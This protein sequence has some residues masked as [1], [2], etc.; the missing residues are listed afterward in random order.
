[1]LDTLPLD[2]LAGSAAEAT[3]R[4]AESSINELLRAGE[5]PLNGATIAI[6][7]GNQVTVHY[8]M[9]H[10]RATLEPELEIG[11]APRLTVTLASFMVAVA[12][13]AALR[14]PYVTLSGRRL[15]IDLA[16]VPA[17]APMARYWPHLRR[18]A[19]TTADRTVRLDVS[20]RIDEESHA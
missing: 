4:L 18:V 2:Q 16:A 19:I 5:P 14:Q 11:R 7:T 12:L 17:L 10:A 3:L 13:R 6:G 8:G 1:M 20:I 9:L 15:T